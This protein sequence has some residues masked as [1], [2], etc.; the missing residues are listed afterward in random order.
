MSDFEPS[1]SLFTFES[2]FGHSQGRDFGTFICSNEGDPF[3]NLCEHAR[4]N[5]LPREV[6]ETMP[7]GC[8]KQVIEVATRADGIADRL[9]S[10]D[11]VA[12]EDL[13]YTPHQQVGSLS[14]TKLQRRK[15]YERANAAAAALFLSAET[16]KS[17]IALYMREARW[18]VHGTIAL[19]RSAYE[20]AVR[21]GSIAVGD[22]DEPNRYMEGPFHVDPDVRR[23]AQI[24]FA[25]AAAACAPL[26]S[27]S[28]ARVTN[29]HLSSFYGWLCGHGHLDLRAVSSADSHPDAYSAMA[30]TIWIVAAFADHIVGIDNFR[31]CLALPDQLPWVNP[32]LPRSPA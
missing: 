32:T 7:W 25:R 14:P 16:L 31:H 22:G 12:R 21:G 2:L 28:D 27:S 4:N 30:F 24:G 15:Q 9:R 26:L 5:L 17:A 18:Y 20:A 8:A 19:V 10:L 23:R 6:L 13:R 1:P 3:D 11:Q 29:A